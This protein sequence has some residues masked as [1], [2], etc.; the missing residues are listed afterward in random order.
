MNSHIKFHSVVMQIP[1]P[2]K[3]PFNIHHLYLLKETAI[4]SLY[5]LKEAR[6]TKGPQLYKVTGVP[7]ERERDSLWNKR[8]ENLH[9]VPA[10]TD[11]DAD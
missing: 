9:T 7:L 1:S 11:M 2:W 6:Q 8:L 10:I 3:H 5:L 4:N